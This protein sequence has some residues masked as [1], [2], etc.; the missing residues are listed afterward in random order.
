MHFEKTVSVNHIRDEVWPNDLKPIY[1]IAGNIGSHCVLRH[2]THCEH[3]EERVY[4][5]VLPSSR[6]RYLNTKLCV[7][8]FTRNIT[9]SVLV[10]S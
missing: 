9:G 5:G 10:T 1:C 4:Q 3:V 8:K 2:Y 7:G 6:L